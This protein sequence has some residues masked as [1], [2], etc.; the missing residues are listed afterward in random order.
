MRVLIIATS[1]AHNII[2]RCNM[3]VSSSRISSNGIMINVFNTKEN[4][5]KSF[6][7]ILRDILKNQYDIIH[8]MEPGYPVFP[9]AFLL[10]FITRKRTIFDTGDIHWRNA[11]L[12]KRSMPFILGVMLCEISAF[13]LAKEIIVRG[14]GAKNELLKFKFLSRKKISVIPDFIEI[15]PEEGYESFSLDSEKKLK[16]NTTVGYVGSLNF[17]NYDG[18]I[19]PRGWE[20]IEVISNLVKKGIEDV[21]I[22]V[23]GTGEALESM[24]QLSL[25]RGVNKFITFKGYVD[26]NDYV[27]VLNSFDICFYE[28]VDIINYRFMTGIKLQEY[29]FLGKPVIAGDIGEAHE[30]LEGLNFCVKPV[31][32]A[33]KLKEEYVES[34]AEKIIEIRSDQNLLQKCHALRNRALLRYG[35]SKLIEDLIK[36]YVRD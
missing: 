32:K 28:S 20:L 36:I 14:I 22:V 34:I 1:R 4:S 13:S 9:L 16:K 5:M 10:F 23:V 24:K 11:K 6:L 7:S 35:Y 21:R 26:Q 19:L 12:R 15:L 3:I 25:N 2:N 29:S 27:K 31:D 33:L 18:I 8:V 17:I 30:L